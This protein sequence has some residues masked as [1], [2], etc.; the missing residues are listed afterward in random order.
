MVFLKSNEQKVKDQKET[1]KCSCGRASCTNNEKFELALFVLQQQINGLNDSY[2]HTPLDP[3]TTDE[4]AEMNEKLDRILSKFNKMSV[5]HEIIFEEIE[6]LRSHITSMNKK[7]WYQLLRAKIGDIAT[8]A[9]LA[10]IIEPVVKDS[11]TELQ[12]FLPTLIP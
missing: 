6:D 12:K 10:P 8:N 2:Y 7:T 4:V 5:E 11:F 1:E 3:F 9:A